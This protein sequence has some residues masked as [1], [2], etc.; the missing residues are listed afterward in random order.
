MDWRNRDTYFNPIRSMV[1]I[2]GIVIVAA[3]VVTGFV[4]MLW[5]TVEMMRMI[6]G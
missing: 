2:L 6:F 3:L 1:C 4:W 5:G